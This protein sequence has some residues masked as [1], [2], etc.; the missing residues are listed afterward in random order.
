MAFLLSLINFEVILDQLGGFYELVLCLETFASY[1]PFL[2]SM[3][4]QKFLSENCAL[5]FAKF[6]RFSFVSD[7]VGTYFQRI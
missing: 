2:G 3:V 7:E 5:S 1:I 4:K 6:R